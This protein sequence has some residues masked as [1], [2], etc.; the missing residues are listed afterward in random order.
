MGVDIETN[1]CSADFCS[2]NS[3]D[4]NFCIQDSFDYPNQMIDDHNVTHTYMD[5]PVMTQTQHFTAI[6]ADTSYSLANIGNTNDYS[7]E[8]FDQRLQEYGNLFPIH[9]DTINNLITLESNQDFN[10]LLDVRPIEYQGN[11]GHVCYTNIRG[12]EV[13]A[14]QT[15]IRDLY[16]D[17]QILM[18]LIPRSTFNLNQTIPQMLD[19]HP[20][21]IFNIATGHSKA[22]H[23]LQFL[24]QY[25]DVVNTFEQGQTKWDVRS[26]LN[27][28]EIH[29]GSNV[30]DF[31]VSCDPISNGVGPLNG[32]VVHL[33]SNKD[34]I[35][36]CHSTSNW[37]RDVTIV[38]DNFNFHRY[39]ES[40]YFTDNNLN[41]V[42]DNFNR[43]DESNYFI[44]NIDYGDNMTHIPENFYDSNYV[45]IDIDIDIDTTSNNLNDIQ[46]TND[47]SES[48]TVENS[49]NSFSEHNLTD[50]LTNVNQGLNIIQGISNFHN[51][52][53]NEKV[54]FIASTIIDTIKNKMTG[55]FDNVKGELNVFTNLVTSLL[56]DGKI[57]IEQLVMDI[58]QNKFGVPLNG[59][60][61]IFDSILHHGKNMG[62]SIKSLIEDCILYC[63][64]YAQVAFLV[65]Q[66][67]QILKS[68]LTHKSVIEVGGFSVLRKEH[69]SFSFKRGYYHTVNLT[70][71]VLGIDVTSRSRH[72]KDADADAKA[73]FD[74]EAKIKAYQVYGI[75][76]EYFNDMK[77][78]VPET[79]YDKYKEMLYFNLSKEYWED[80]NNL[81]DEEKKKYESAMFESDE[82]KTKR[83]KYEI[84]GK[85]FSYFDTNGSQDIYHFVCD[86]KSDFLKC[87]NNTERA[88]FLYSLFNETGHSSD[89]QFHF[90]EFTR[91]ILELF[92]IDIV[93]FENYIN[94]QNNIS[95]DK[96]DAQVKKQKE[97]EAKDNQDF[98][99]QLRN[100]RTATQNSSLTSFNT[101]Q[102]NDKKNNEEQ[103]SLVEIRKFAHMEL[104]KYEI[105]A[106]FVFQTIYSSVTSNLLFTFVY[107]DKEYLR[108]RHEGFNYIPSKTLEITGGCAQSYIST[109]IANHITLDLSL[110][111]RFLNVSDETFQYFVKPNVLFLTSMGVSSIVK[112]TNKNVRKQ[113]VGK[114]LFEIGENVLKTNGVNVINYYKA[115][116]ADLIENV[117][118]YVDN[119]LK[120]NF[121]NYSIY[122]D[123]LIAFIKSYGIESTL[124]ESLNYCLIGSSISMTLTV[125]FAT[126][127]IKSLIFPEIKPKYVDVQN[128]KA[129]EMNNKETMRLV[130]DLSNNNVS[131][132]KKNS[133]KRNLQLNGIINYDKLPIVNNKIINIQSKYYGMDLIF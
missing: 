32:N 90:S 120:L 76:Y 88:M 16:N 126:R 38:D 78:N 44:E 91:F 27:K 4:T 92:K 21:C 108:I 116:D 53:H 130:D 9:Q 133:I 48:K 81:T 109:V 127:I 50:T 85:K 103:Y 8:R 97:T 10:Y 11:V 117:V 73:K 131:Q 94:F 65:F 31:R 62:E 36:E 2:T 84:L 63:V 18:G 86:L 40:N 20:E 93:K 129:I 46:T 45:D 61:N 112:L 39:D 47:N 1:F 105:S 75:D 12:T 98:L 124:T 6:L 19:N 13:H 82:K 57:K 74:A 58:C 22:G 69:P 83:I 122:Q 119:Y 123:S 132:M 67:F 56:Q 104:L 125:M 111:E 99:I 52:T 29:D 113:N 15:G 7:Y 102:K 68:F 24:N 71:D 70:N 59:I 26:L 34:G 41:I 101:Q 115:F 35:F 72:T 42:P 23:D 60:R 100:K 89:D 107:L 5:K 77:D 66:S 110:R 28:Y 106:D 17:A 114:Q 14:P 55:V 87:T 80:I 121:Q 43:Y 3:C 33:N 95:D 25:F 64:P 79:R 128:L 37:I 118:T 30:T 51:F 54:L 49:D 96:L